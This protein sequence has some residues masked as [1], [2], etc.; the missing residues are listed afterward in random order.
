MPSKQPKVAGRRLSPRPQHGSSCSSLVDVF[1]VFCSRFVFVGCQYRVA[2]AKVHTPAH[3][4]QHLPHLVLG[5]VPLITKRIVISNNPISDT[6]LLFLTP[7]FCA[8]R[9]RAVMSGSHRLSCQRVS[10]L[11]DLY[12]AAGPH[13]PPNK[14]QSICTRSGSVLGKHSSSFSSRSSSREIFQAPSVSLQ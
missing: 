1:A 5:T 8:A 4:A 2:V 3:S 6:S 7:V 9:P 12:A 14:S 13:Q 11:S 10:P